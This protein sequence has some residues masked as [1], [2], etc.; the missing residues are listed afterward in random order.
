MKSQSSRYRSYYAILYWLCK[1]FIV[2]L[3]IFFSITLI[4]QSDIDRDS[5]YKIKMDEILKSEVADTIKLKILIEEIGTRSSLKSLLPFQY[6]KEGKILAE[7][8]NQD[9]WNYKL[10]IVLANLF[11]EIR[12]FTL[13]QKAYQQALIYLEKSNNL[14]EIL[15]IKL[16]L[17]G[18]CESSESPDKAL[19]IAYDAL[20]LS[21]KID[22]IATGKVY[23][24]LGFLYFYNN[25]Q[26]LGIE[27]LLL[28]IDVYKKYDK[29]YELSL[30]Y[31]ELALMHLALS[32]FVK[33][34]EYIDKAIE[35]A[36]KNLI[37]GFKQHLKYV[38][39]R[40]LIL[41][42]SEKYNEALIEYDYVE[43]LTYGID[44]LKEFYYL[45][46]YKKAEFTFLNKQFGRSKAIYIEIVNRPDIEYNPWVSDIY[47][48]LSKVY[49]EEGKL[50]SAFIWN[51]KNYYRNNAEY[52]S[53]RLIHKENLRN[54][55]ETEQ[56]EALIKLQTEQIRSVR[57][58]M[59][60][61][62][63]TA[64]VM[65]LLFFQSYNNSKARKK[66]SQALEES[67]SNLD[68]ENKQ[69][70][71]LL[72]EIH[73]RVK[74]NLQTISS[75]L[76]LQSYNIE[77]EAI[78]KSIDISQQRVESMA[79]IHKSLYQTDDLSAIELKGY[80][81][82]LMANLSKSYDIHGNV[83][84]KVEMEPIHLDIDTTIPLGLIV[85]ELVTNSFKYAFLEIE[86]GEIAISLVKIREKHILKLSD[87]GIGK[88][89]GVKEN[90]G[91]QLIGLLV[92]QIDGQ[93]KEVNNNGYTCEIIF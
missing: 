4:G 79:L 65:G 92:R 38:Q 15:D 53:K 32:E 66:I 51:Q 41:G 3:L 47:L 84:M 82:K 71:T 74:N 2:G 50:D 89:D 39:N 24:H 72:K 20:K 61:S 46:S 70:E 34:L 1:S 30:I 43:K 60:L 5:L 56:K 81:T 22:E 58:I 87:N 83:L 8:I 33:A 62:L 63:M 93:M 27:Q 35:V 13:Q 42:N 77:D 49:V 57:V 76:Y 14:R 44:S 80:F 40:G 37:W 45:N 21:K 29:Q 78:K 10:N 26:I 67:N 68:R 69:N 7:R 12:D 54:F 73:H 52:A 86:N 36:K 11:G 18:S 19:S 9:Y 75:L 85:N 28:S 48:N 23:G 16:A 59:I 90:F 88:P 55:Y 64:G 25:E 6:F 31:Q 17:S 91:T